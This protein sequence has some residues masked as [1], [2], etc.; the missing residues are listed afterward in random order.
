[1]QPVTVKG[2][3]LSDQQARLW[4]AQQRSIAYRC[5]CQIHIQGEIDLRKLQLAFQMLIARHT[6]LRMRLHSIPGMDMPMQ[7]ISPEDGLNYQ[8]INLEGLTPAHRFKSIQAY[9][10]IAQEVP[11]DLQEGPLLHCTLLRE[12]TTSAV[13]FLALPAI[14]ADAAT[15]KIL[16]TE[17]RAALS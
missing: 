16:I 5:L 10:R 13:L 8:V 14:C 4:S 15:L 7:F 17:T 1:M 11:F 6:I 2:F 9:K 12:T 3:R